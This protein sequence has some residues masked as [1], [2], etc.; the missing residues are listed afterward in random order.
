MLCCRVVS[1]SCKLKMCIKKGMLLCVRGLIKRYI[2]VYSIL[3][4][5]SNSCFKESDLK[6][7]RY[8][9]SKHKTWLHCWKLNKREIIP[10]QGNCAF[11]CVCGG[12]GVKIIFEL[13]WLHLIFIEE[14]SLCHKLLFSNFDIFATQCH[15][16]LIF[17]TLNAVRS[18]IPSLKCL[19]FTLSGCKDYKRLQEI[20]KNWIC[21]KDSIPLISF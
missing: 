20:T 9:F 3:L 4:R 18:N 10:L 19:R 15:R 7:C 11:M 14:L 6:R 12:R 21:G 13:N 1:S 16:Y 5:E 17:Q 2:S 8:N